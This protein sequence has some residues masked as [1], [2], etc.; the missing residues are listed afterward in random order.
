[1]GVWGFAW[2]IKPDNILVNARRSKVKVRCWGSGY[3]VWG[4]VGLPWGIK[5][6]NILVNARRSKVKVR[7]EAHG[8]MFGLV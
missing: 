5:P 6:D 8:P 2:G 4:F 7:L 1:L 3:R